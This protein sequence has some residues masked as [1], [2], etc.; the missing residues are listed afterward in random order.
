MTQNEAAPTGG[1]KALAEGRQ[2]MYRIDPRLLNVKEGWNARDIKTTENAEHIDMLAQSIA[3]VG[4]KEPLT[5]YMEGDKV[6]IE[7][8]HCRYFGTMRAIEH[9]GAE[10]KT[11]NVKTGDRY[12]TE[13]DR[14]FSQ[15][16]RNSGKRLS[17]MEQSTVFK[18]LIDF[19][20]DEAMIA[21]KSGISGKWVKDLLN[22]SAAPEAVKKFVRD[23][24]VAPSLAIETLAKSKDGKEAAEKLKAAVTTASA[25]GAER[26][27]KKHTKPKEPTA[28]KKRKTPMTEFEIFSGGWTG[29]A[30]SEDGGSVEASYAAWQKANNRG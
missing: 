30:T 25:A 24:K 8:G 28:A 14:I 1:L 5:V 4:V 17:P 15:I 7:D 21:K 13:G 2:D 29:Y 9:Y 3:E 12:A 19:G 10:I 26:A 22:L 16:V 18:R 6:Y 23:G 27:T 20:W 11:V